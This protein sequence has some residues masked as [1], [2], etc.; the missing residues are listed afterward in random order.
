MINAARAIHRNARRFSL[1]PAICLVFAA[2][3]LAIS[4]YPSQAPHSSSH[5]FSGTWKAVFNEKTI[6]VLRLQAEDEHPSGTIQ[7]AGFQL[8]LEGDGSIMTVT[9]GQLDKPINL[10]NIKHDRKTLSFD[11]VDSDGDTDKFQMELT[12]NGSA[13]LQWVGLP[14]G[15]KAQPIAVTR[16]STPSTQ[17][18]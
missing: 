12:D 8:D 1:L 2:V 17:A 14:A 3:A 7:L 16:E 18:N 5:G 9:D 10:K 15:L 6:I 11:F 4:A 13:K